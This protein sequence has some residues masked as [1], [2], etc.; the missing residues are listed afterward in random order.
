M[1]AELTLVCPT[2]AET[3]RMA[4]TVAGALRAGDVLALTG[5]LGAG[6]TC[7]VQGAAAALGVR[8]RVTSP[9]F[10]LRR[11]YQGRLPLLHFDVYRLETL[12]QVVE[13]GYEQAGDGTHVTFIEWG[14]AVSPL[15]PPEHLEV[16]FRLSDPGEA[17]APDPAGDGS[18][19][20]HVVLR[21]HGSGWRRRIA[22]LSA[23]LRPWRQDP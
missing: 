9:S 1:G 6:K 3:R 11:E 19:Q 5:E 15:L 10:V 14:D 23:D 13:L 18:E 20:R 8:E 12:Q 21:A 22:A 4:G 7:F 16:E 17:G 2:P